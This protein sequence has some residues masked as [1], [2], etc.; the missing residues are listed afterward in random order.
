MFLSLNIRCLPVAIALQLVGTPVARGTDTI[1]VDPGRFGAD[2]EHDLLV[3]SDDVAAI[4][5]AWPEEKSV[6]LLDH[7]YTFD[8]PVAEVQTGV[9]YAV[10]DQ[11]SAYT[12]YFT[13]LPLITVNTPHTIVDEPMVHATFTLASVG[14]APIVADMGIEFRGSWSQTFPKKSYRI[15]FWSGPDEETDLQL[16]G[17]RED[18]DWNLQA[19]YNEPLRVRSPVNNRIWRDMHAPYYMDSEPN[20]LSGIRMEYVELFLNGTYRGVYAVGEPVDRKQLKLQEYEEGLRGELY[21]GYTWGATTFSELPPYNN[22]EPT[23]GGF[24]H[25]YPEEPIEWGHVHDLV[26]FVMNSSSVEFNAEYADRFHVPNAV[27]Y[28]ILLNALRLTDNT[29]KNIFLARYDAGEPY[30]YVPWD[31]D[32][33]VGTIWDGSEQNIT[34]GLLRNGFYQRLLGDCSVGGFVDR[35]QARWAELRGDLITT[36]ALMGR[37]RAVFDRLE[38]N[39]VYEREQLVWPEYVHDPG[40][41]TYMSDW[42][43]ARLTHLDSTFA[44]L[45]IGMGVNDRLAD[46]GPLR[47]YPNPARDRV[48][49]DTGTGT[50]GASLE[51]EL[52]DLAGR[53]VM[54]TTVAGTTTLVQLPPLS[55]GIY[56]ITVHGQGGMRTQRL[57]IG[58]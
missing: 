23:W 22:A 48:W 19:L 13:E 35:L 11:D 44:G 42:L 32:G 40:H 37:Y 52:N 49:I 58:E 3:V 7:H 56:M 51:V 43:D 10:T 27:D 9:P 25:D 6:I 18:D 57:V 36:P 4:N 30:F 38:A 24:E 53:S 34:T 14:D 33:S 15:E 12:L 50:D 2:A 16:L 54:R 55:D 47:L 1:V 8:V 28:F 39:A 21:K 45:C 31:L 17:M 29:G 41:L 26:D 46:A 20:A 5:A